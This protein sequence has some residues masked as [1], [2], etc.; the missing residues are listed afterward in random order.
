MKLIGFWFL[1]L[2]AVLVPVSATIAASMMCPPA[3]VAKHSPVRA[4]EA[5]IGSTSKHLVTKF[6]GHARYEKAKVLQKKSSG[7]DEQAQNC[8]DVTPCSHCASCGSCVSMAAFT[9]AA[10][11]ARNPSMAAL[12]EPGYP[13]VEFLRA[14]LERPP[15]I[16]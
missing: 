6:M 7:S 5:R 1:V 8:C 9:T 15:R 10:M 11:D 12:S 13:R 4:N 2:L 3:L 14:G 16:C